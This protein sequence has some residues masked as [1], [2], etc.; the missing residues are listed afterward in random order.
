MLTS[1]D[2]SA[3]LLLMCLVMKVLT[4]QKLRRLT[5]KKNLFYTSSNVQGVKNLAPKW[6]VDLYQQTISRA[7]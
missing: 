7:S 3:C 5:T 1:R 6:Q 2:I 4:E